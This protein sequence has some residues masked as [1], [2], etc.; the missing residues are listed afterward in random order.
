VARAHAAWHHGLVM[1][2]VYINLTIRIWAEEGVYLADILEIDQLTHGKTVEEA[3]FMAQDA[4]KVYFAACA[5]LGTL[6]AEL[7]KLGAARRPVRA[8]LHFETPGAPVE[9]ELALVA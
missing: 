7:A 4:I 9:R 8:H 5:E 2:P 1:P 3:I 6:D